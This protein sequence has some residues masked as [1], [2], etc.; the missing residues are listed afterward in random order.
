MKVYLG[1]GSLACIINLLIA[2]VSNVLMKLG[3]QGKETEDFSEQWLFSNLETII[4]KA[5]LVP[6][7]SFLIW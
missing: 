1:I 7:N 6:D 4:V 2:P 3:Y 5:T